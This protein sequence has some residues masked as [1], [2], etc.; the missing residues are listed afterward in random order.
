LLVTVYSIC[1]HNKFSLEVS[2]FKV[3][4]IS[5]AMKVVWG[6]VPGSTLQQVQQCRSCAFQTYR[7]G[8]SQSAALFQLRFPAPLSPFP[9]PSFSTLL[10]FHHPSLPLLL[11]PAMES[12]G[13]QLPQRGPGRSPGCGRILLHCTL[14]KRIW[15]QH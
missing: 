8:L 15:L 1:S 10:S 6:T 4:V 5:D 7:A 12:V 13:V 3:R 11:K 14:A 9:S 2:I